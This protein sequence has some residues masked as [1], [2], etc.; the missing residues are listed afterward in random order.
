MQCATCL[1]DFPNQ[2][3]SCPRC[4]KPLKAIDETPL[5]AAPSTASRVLEFPAPTDARPQWRQEASARLR[6][7]QEKKGR[8][9]SNNGTAAGPSDAP[10][11][12]SSRKNG[13]V[14][15]LTQR[16][17][18][19]ERVVRALQRVER[20]KQT[21]PD[22]EPKRPVLV[23]APPPTT[24]APPPPATAVALTP[25][26]AEI[27]PL[28]P[29]SPLDDLATTKVSSGLEH[30]LRLPLTITEKKNQTV[31]PKMLAMATAPIREPA[32]L[33]ARREIAP[34]RE[35]KPVAP[36]PVPLPAPPRPAPTVLRIVPPPV[37]ETP[38][39]QPEVAPPTVTLPVAQPEAPS[40]RLLRVAVVED[41]PPATVEA[42]HEETT[43]R[44][45]RKMLA[46]V[47][48]SGDLA[49]VALRAVAAGVDWL[50]ALVASLPLLLIAVTYSEEWRWSSLA[51]LL[52]GNMVA[53]MGLYA[54]FLTRYAGRTWGQELLFL[55]VAQVEDGTRPTL[56]QCALRTLAYLAWPIT[57]GGGLLYALWDAEGRAWHDKFSGTIVLRS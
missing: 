22:F 39:A 52:V 24:A 42:E 46:V 38:V 4:R 27:E 6:E 29:A 31:A 36:Q 2:I 19:D 16:A 34:A 53:F 15:S 17:A 10:A 43:G 1:T 40:P 12:A 13:S 26:V 5:S 56:Q 33:A 49:P 7:Y 37:A 30:G 25:V 57:F 44:D 45:W 23:P 35:V 32:P 21:A 54:T 51:L 47:G 14:I 8:L 3:S 9:Q 11:T 50:L 28:G 48:Q 20:A 18:M 55:H 41:A